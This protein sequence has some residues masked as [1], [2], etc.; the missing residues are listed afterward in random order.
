MRVRAVQTSESERVAVISAVLLTED[1]YKSDREKGRMLE[2][3]R[4]WLGR[5]GSS[6]IIELHPR[7]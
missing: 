1:C 3:S 7:T 4:H 2:Q 5:R 6:D